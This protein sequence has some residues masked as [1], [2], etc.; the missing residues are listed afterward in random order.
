MSGNFSKVFND[1]DNRSYSMGGPIAQPHGCDSAS[2]AE[3]S[4][5]VVPASQNPFY[6][7]TSHMDTIQRFEWSSPLGANGSTSNYHFSPHQINTNPGI[8]PFIRDLFPEICSDV[9]K[10][11]IS[12]NPTA[13]NDM[14]GNPTDGSYINGT[15]M[16][17]S[18]PVP[19][20]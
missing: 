14:G 9:N 15:S 18:F 1:L 20:R 10:G 4:S 11:A 13:R 19:E 3:P 17:T 7:S 12:G 5:P 2:T 16:H 6:M 8:E